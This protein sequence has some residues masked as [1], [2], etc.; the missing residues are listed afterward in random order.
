MDAVR[1]GGV[2][3][4]HLQSA[5]RVAHLADRGGR[6]ISVEQGAEALEEGDV[7]GPALVVDVVLEIIGVDRRRD[8]SVALALGQRRIV[9][10]P[11]RMK[12]EIDRVETKAVDATVEPEAYRVEQR[13]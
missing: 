13:V 2:V 4:D 8:G 3:G 7:L 11:G 1:A 10:Q 12:V 5:L 6:R 9:L